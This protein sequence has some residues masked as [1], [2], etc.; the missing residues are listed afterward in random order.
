MRRLTVSLV[1]IL[2]VAFCPASAQFENRTTATVG[3][4]N[5]KGRPTGISTTRAEKLAKGIADL[6]ADVLVLCEVSSDAIL[7]TIVKRVAGHGLKYQA[8]MPAQESD[9]KIAVLAKE[10]IELKDVT[11]IEGSGF[12]DGKSIRKALSGFVRIGKF[13]FRLVGVH[14][15]SA[16]DAT[17]WK[18][19][20]E[21]NVVIAKFV[22]DTLDAGTERDVLIVGDYNMIPVEDDDNFKSLNPTGFLRFISSEVITPPIF[23]HISASGGQG[24]L[25][26]GFAIS[27]GHTKE[28]V[29]GSL[30]VFPLNKSFNM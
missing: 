15:K 27:E 16:R 3:A 24:N 9:I 8:V 30:R 2:F 11:L 25:L 14:L 10:G 17:S 5:V 12:G 20:S 4:W 6:D 22:K 18:K 29:R 7:A 19:R 26:D 28:Y 21:Q 1:A 13:D 23:S